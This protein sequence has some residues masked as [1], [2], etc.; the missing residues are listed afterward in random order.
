MPSAEPLVVARARAFKA[1]LLQRETA[2][3]AEMAR[4]WRL[5]E[6]ALESEIERLA[7]FAAAEKEAGRTLT[8]EMLLTMDRYQSLLAQSRSELLRYIVWAEGEIGGEQLRLA[9]LG[10]EQAAELVGLQTGAGLTGLFDRLPVAA[11]EEMVGM[12]GDGSPLR[13]LLSQAWP[14][15]VE[16]LTNELVTGIAIG[17]NPR[18]IARLMTEKGLAQGLNRVMVIARTEQLRAY[19]QASQM[20]YRSSPVVTSYRR[21]S[22]HDDRVCIGCLVMDGQE[23]DLAT[24]F[25]EHPQGRCAMV[26]VVSGGAPVTWQSGEEWLSAQSQAT[27]ESILGPQR[28]ELWSEGRVAFRRMATLR[29]NETWGNAWTPTPIQDLTR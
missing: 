26:P 15:A 13:T 4:R 14:D 27:Q 5:V 3:M 29:T 12:A 1:A 11:V 28:Y 21:L 9:R 24:E 2:Q 25:E 18:T 10:L 6:V 19:R 7:L 22:A 20:Q 23:V 16:G 17:R 8:R